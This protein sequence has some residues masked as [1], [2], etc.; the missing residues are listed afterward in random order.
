[1]AI[2]KQAFLLFI[3]LYLCPN[4]ALQ[5]QCTFIGKVK[6]SETGKPLEGATVTFARFDVRGTMP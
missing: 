2:F 3:A 6:D 4:A 1:M 5:A